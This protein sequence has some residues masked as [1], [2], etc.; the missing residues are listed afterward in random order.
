MGGTMRRPI[1]PLL[2]MQLETVGEVVR[3]LRSRLGLEQVELARKCGW[4]DAS[5]V[6]RIETDRIH[7]TRRTLLKLADNLSKP[8]VTGTAAEVRA[9]LFL[10]AG[11]LPT[12]REIEELGDKLPDIASWSYPAS[13]MDF[14]WYLWRANDLFTKGLGLPEK[15]IGRH[16]VEMFFEEDGPIRKQFGDIW[17]DLAQITVSNFRAD[18]EHRTQ[19]RWFVKL[20][21]SLG[22]LPD[23]EP[24]W[25]K[26]VGSTESVMGWSSTSVDGGKVG[27]L[28]AQIT[29]DPRLIVGQ[30]V[31]DDEAG[32]EQMLKYG[33]LLG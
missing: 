21:A 28:R 25:N 24:M 12:A 4:R 1:T 2:T 23:F 26:A 33:A 10:A 5:A 14:G 31:P 13:I 29:A 16:Y 27:G 18:T 3:V 17:G 9:L 6:S 32:R 19:Q 22:R 11:N 8:D 15:H 20:R 7:P 30:L